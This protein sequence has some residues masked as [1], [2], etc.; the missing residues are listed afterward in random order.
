MLLAACR[1]LTPAEYKNLLC[2][3]VVTAFRY[4]VIGAQRTGDQERLSHQIAM[5][6]HRSELVGLAAVLQALLP[7]YR[8]D[9][10]FR[11]DCREKSQNQPEPQRQGGAALAAGAGVRRSWRRSRPSSAG[12]QYRARFP[13]GC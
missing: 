4:N 5:Q 11:A 13:A 3:T 1:K 9:V 6:L 12:F 7:V 10:A 8:S 2:A